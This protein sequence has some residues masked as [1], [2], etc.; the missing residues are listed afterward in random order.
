MKL[1][2]SLFDEV[3][4]DDVNDDNDEVI[5]T[6]G[7]LMM[8]IHILRKGRNVSGKTLY[9]FYDSMRRISL[10][11]QEN[12]DFDKMPKPTVLENYKN[13]SNPNIPLPYKS[14]GCRLTR[15]SFITVRFDYLKMNFN[16]VTKISQFLI[17]LFSKLRY[18]CNRIFDITFNRYDDSL[19]DKDVCF[20]TLSFY[21]LNAITSRY[22]YN[23]KKLFPRGM[24]SLYRL[25]LGWSD[26]KIPNIKDLDNYS[27]LN[28]NTNN[29]LISA[30]IANNLVRAGL[31]DNVNED[32]LI[33]LSEK[34]T[35]GG[36]VHIANIR[37]L[38]MI[39]IIKNGRD[40]AFPI[41]FVSYYSNYVTDEQI[42]VDFTS[43]DNNNIFIDGELNP[44]IKIPYLNSNIEK[45][46]EE[47]RFCT[48]VYNI[49]R[50]SDCKFLSSKW[51]NKVEINYSLNK[52][53]SLYKVRCGDENGQSYAFMDLDGN[54]VK[55]KWFTNSTKSFNSLGYAAVAEKEDEFYIVNTNL[56]RLFGPYKS[57]FDYNAYKCNNIIKMFGVVE[58]D[59]VTK[60]TIMSDLSVV[61][62]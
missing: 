50:L 29:F 46:F 1:N 44:K 26:D 9:D 7:M 35:S 37:C 54:I 43:F 21:A 24:T 16:N 5:D 23:Q 17:R 59:G 42:I 6:S 8:N 27:V 38:S 53:N 52:D 62:A 45:T 4:L 34:K 33:Y 40:V 12:V 56:D 15:E 39:N 30:S 51:F 2:E 36:T 31:F 58:Q 60:K 48:E 61:D 3:E 19:K 57:V 13:G 20:F 47:L 55:D 11:F 32:N 28:F 25:L 41:W 49:I 22:S 14:S 18:S 10:L